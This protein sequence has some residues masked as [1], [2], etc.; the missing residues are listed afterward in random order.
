M[1]T[2]FKLCE[3][4]YYIGFNMHKSGY[5]IKF[6]FDLGKL[7]FLYRFLSNLLVFNESMATELETILSTQNPS[8]SRL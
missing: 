6:M 1:S 2:T 4:K 8:F 7:P 3:N 5:F